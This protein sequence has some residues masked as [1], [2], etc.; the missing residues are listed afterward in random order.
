LQ[1]LIDS[2]HFVE[3]WAEESIE[4][5]G[6][7]RQDLRTALICCTIVNSNPWRKQGAQP[8]NLHDFLKIFE[9]HRQPKEEQTPEQ[10]VQVLKL[11]NAV[12]GGEE[13]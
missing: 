10:Q 11:W 6:E 9:F 3:L 7:F 1:R 12:L 4:P 13:K 8:A 5:R 2:R